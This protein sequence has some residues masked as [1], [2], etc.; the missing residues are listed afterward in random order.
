MR[1]ALSVAAALLFACPAMADDPKSPAFP[2][3]LLFIHASNYLYL[4]PLTHAA[5]MG[6]DRVR[7]SAERLAEAL[8]VPMAA[9]NQQLFV[10]ADTLGPPDGRFPTKEMILKT[11]DNFV[12]TTRG[13]DR[14]VIY[15]GVHAT[16]K[17][18]KA[19][20][21]PV[22][23]NLDDPTT[24]VPV[25]AIYAKLKDLEAT[26]KVVIWDV[27]RTNP[28]RVRVRRDS[29]P[30]TE[31]LFKALS[32][33]PPGVQALISCSPGEQALEYFTPRGPA[34]L[35]AGS[36]F[37][38]AIR[39]SAA[40]ERS[41]NPKATPDDPI[42][43]DAFHKSSL[44]IV[45]ELAKLAGVTQ[46]PAVAGT[47][48]KPE[49]AFD[50]KEAAAKRFDWPALK[51]A[52]VDDVKAIL[53]ELA[54]PPLGDDPLSP[55]FPFSADALKDFA[56]DAILD[57][58]LKAPEKYPLRVATLRAL[59]AMRDSWPLGTK[60]AKSMTSI[61]APLNDRIKKLVAD[62]QLPFALAI[63]KLELELENLQGVAD[64]RAGETKRWQAHYDYAIAQLRLRLVL[65]NEFNVSLGKVRTETLPDLPPG[66]PG[67]R[68]VPSDKLQSG[69]SVRVLLETATEDFNRL[70]NNWKGTPWEVLA[71]RELAVLPGLKWEPIPAPKP[72]G[73]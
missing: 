52:P 37:L 17:D 8:R 22:E 5:P 24:L 64:K 14:V 23:G 32:A 66:S 6:A 25:S 42:P 30:M 9:D 46:T 20:I 12:T 1:L 58:I 69:K 19:Y 15:F 33:A 13:Q 71:R 59:Q 54:L 51:T 68:L 27:C 4:T 43:V 41:G 62:A 18:G 49:T 56:A 10:L 61:N 70:A 36:A 34:G 35:F 48:V 72:D 60:E 2:R 65:L 39:Q 67:W 38:D 73:K 55:D 63:A 44:K 7:P 29:G 28:E 31:P 26:Q 16:E 45:T 11:L 53:S 3:R 40:D 21:V 57:E 47:P 50:P